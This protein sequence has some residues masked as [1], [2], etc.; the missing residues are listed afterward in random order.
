MSPAENARAAAN[1]LK[2]CELHE[3]GVAEKKA[4]L[5]KEHPDLDEDTIEVM[6]FYW[7]NFPASEEYDP[8]YFRTRFFIDDRPVTAEEQALLEERL[9]EYRANP[10]S[11]RPWSEVLDELRC[12]RC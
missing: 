6:L 9:A 8:A 11:A 12:P 4:E 7:L 3:A 1:L 5:R 2:A 10:T